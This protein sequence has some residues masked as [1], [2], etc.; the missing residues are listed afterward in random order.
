ML[1]SFVAVLAVMVARRSTFRFGRA[2]EY[3]ALAPQ[4]MPG[5]IIGIGFFWAFAYAPFGTGQL[6]QGTLCG[7]DHRLRPACTAQRVRLGGSVDHADRSG[8]RQRRPRRR[9]R[10]AH[11]VLPDPA[12]ACSRRRSRARSIL[13]FVTMLKEYSPAVFLS[14]A[15]TN[16]LGTTMLELW[17][18]G[19]TGSVAALA[20][21]QI[22]ITA[23]FVAL[24]GLLMKGKDHA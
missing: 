17:V 7:T 12:C 4:A 5:I 10:L 22:A 8:A 23:A 13:T 11:D 21:I 2:V 15:D 3:L 18:Q 16:I 1:V 6:L 24:A 19:S 20:T 14:S 9:R